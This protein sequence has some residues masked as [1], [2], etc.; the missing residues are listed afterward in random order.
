[1]NLNESKVKVKKAFPFPGM[2]DGS[3]DSA[4]DNIS[5]T[6]QKHIERGSKILDFGSGSC[7]KTAVI[8][9]L[10]YECSAFDDFGD[11][12][13]RQGRDH[14]NLGSWRGNA[15]AA[16]AQPHRSCVSCRRPRRY[17]H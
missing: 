5:N 2:L 1:M 9:C 12:W 10:G 3:F 14:A 13:H 7:E 6:I 11:E 16:P 8:Q 17:R 4:L 15:N